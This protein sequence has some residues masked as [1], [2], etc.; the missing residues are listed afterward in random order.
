MKAATLQTQQPRTLE[1]G[2]STKSGSKR[3]TQRSSRPKRAIS[4]C[5]RAT[6]GLGLR[7]TKEMGKLLRGLKQEPDEDGL[8]R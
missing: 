8:V 3:A 4:G 1:M 6:S 5:S 7:G 2:T